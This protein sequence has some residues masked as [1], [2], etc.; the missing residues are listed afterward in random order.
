MR[1]I[2]I[3]LA[4]LLPVSDAAQAVKAIPQVASLKS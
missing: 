1:T 4:L 2:A 3:L